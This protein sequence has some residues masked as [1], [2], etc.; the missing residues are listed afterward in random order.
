MGRLEGEV[1][2]VTNCWQIR[3][4]WRRTLEEAMTVV[5]MMKGGG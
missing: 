5:D 3:E 4:S 2:L 1:E